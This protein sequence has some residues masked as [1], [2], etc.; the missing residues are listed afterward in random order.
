MSALDLLLGTRRLRRKIEVQA[1]QL[2]RDIEHEQLAR[3]HLRQ[4]FV[5]R[6]TSPLG[7]LSAVGAGFVAG[8]IGGRS[9]NTDR[10]AHAVASAITLAIAAA[11]SVAVQVALPMANEWFQS[12]FANHKND[13]EKIAGAPK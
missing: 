11:R 12:K 1:Q 8:K 13:E 5:Q 4:T 2:H 10:A 6:V 7:L 9:S 3:A